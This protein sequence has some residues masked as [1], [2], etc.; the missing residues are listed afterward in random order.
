MIKK[1]K[2]TKTFLFKFRKEYK[3]ILYYNKR[4]WKKGKAKEF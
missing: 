1:K 2:I 3:K 4:Q